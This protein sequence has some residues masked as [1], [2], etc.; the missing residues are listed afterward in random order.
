MAVVVVDSDPAWPGEFQ[1]ERAL[2][3]GA[4]RAWLVDDVHHIGSTSVPGLPAK[5]ILDMIAGVG[6]LADAD[7]AEPA[8]AAL[9]YERVP[10]RVD[11]VLFVKATDGV[12]TRHLHLVV[13]G[14][15]LW[16]E[17]LAF[18]D[19]LLADPALVQ[20]YRALKEDL[21]RRSGGAP[22]APADKRA[23]VRRVLAAAGV[24]LR[25]DRHDRRYLRSEAGRK[26]RQ[27]G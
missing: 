9:G 5:P 17:R 24:H 3:T 1:A 2:L 20:E 21:L 7:A 22:Y 25:E 27:E 15:D 11:A 12:H 19:A 8:L 14:A 18:R 10:H 4:L 26:G 13:P 23:F 16:R 6:T